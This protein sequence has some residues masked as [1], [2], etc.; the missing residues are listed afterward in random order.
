MQNRLI[1]ALLTCAFSAFSAS[2]SAVPVTVLQNG[3]NTLFI[4]GTVAGGAGTPTATG[5]DAAPDAAPQPPSFYAGGFTLVYAPI[6]DLVIVAQS[7]DAAPAPSPDAAPTPTFGSGAGNFI[8]PVNIV[9][10]TAVPEPSALLLVSLG[11]G[12]LAAL[13]GRRRQ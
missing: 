12:A 3:G 9:A 4:S 13:R 10:P 7:P 2:A 8:G 11:L 6:P 1:T 5:S